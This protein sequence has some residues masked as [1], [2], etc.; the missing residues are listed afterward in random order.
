M[1]LGEAV[2]SILAIGVGCRKGCSAAAIVGLIE[3]VRAAAPAGLMVGLFTIVDKAEEPGLLD[4]AC[5]LG[6]GLVCL[7]RDALRAVMPSVETRSAAAEARFGIASVSEAA[8]L[9]G[10]GPGAHLVVRRIAANGATC[11]VAAGADRP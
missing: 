5:C 1:G 9:A 11:A 4:A 2:T 10:A 6:L 3:Q 8:A 7:S